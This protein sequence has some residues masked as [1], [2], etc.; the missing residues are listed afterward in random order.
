MRKSSIRLG[1]KKLAAMVEEATTDCY[2]ES[3]Q[4]VPILALPLPSPP[5]AGAEWIEACRRW[6]RGDY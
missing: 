2:N 4:A 3:E 6:L 5:P 1:A